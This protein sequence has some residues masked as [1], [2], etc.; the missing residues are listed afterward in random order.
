[1]APGLSRY[2][3]EQGG[4]A[5][6]DLVANLRGV[7]I[8]SDRLFWDG[9]KDRTQFAGSLTAGD[10]ATVLPQWGYAASIST[11]RTVVDANL[12]WR[13]SPAAVD[14]ARL[15]GEAAFEAENGRFLAVTQGAD[16]MKIFSLV[17]F[18]TIAKRLNFDFSDVVG[19]GV[20]FDTLTATTEFREGS[21]QFLKPMT[22]EGSGSNFRIGG[23]VD[24]VG[25][26][27]DNE[28]IVTLPVSQGLPWYAAYIALANPLAG[29]GVLVGERVLR[30]PLE[31]FS[32]AKYEISG[33]LDEPELKFVGVWDTTMDQPQASLEPLE[34][35]GVE[36]EP[37][38]DPVEPGAE[39][40]GRPAEETEPL[41]N[42][43][44]TT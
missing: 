9:I 23:T 20:S 27:L 6:Y 28:M 15:M 13:G 12:N 7:H 24:L 18:S 19:E 10:L 41:Q 17:N 5:L 32:S 35:D 26:A 22:V 42:T 38:E 8:A 25:G 11:E 39:P 40:T 30:K 37:T 4:V 1:M 14:L 29:L 2:R 31:Q 34:S 3:P 16:A 21:L 33:T 44:T 43:G 36:A